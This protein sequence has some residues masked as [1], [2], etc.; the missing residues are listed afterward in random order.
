M[1]LFKP[2]AWT[3]SAR[4]LIFSNYDMF[5]LL[6]SKFSTNIIQ[7]AYESQSKYF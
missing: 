6:A 5:I 4:R 1:L 2:F 7:N 3:W